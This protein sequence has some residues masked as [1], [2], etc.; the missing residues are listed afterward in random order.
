MP[1][2][3]VQISVRR[4]DEETVGGTHLMF[5]LQEERESMRR[6]LNQSRKG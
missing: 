4:Q 1:V 5:G 6:Q 2:G 3:S